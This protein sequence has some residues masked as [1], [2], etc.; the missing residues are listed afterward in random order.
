MAIGA[1][2]LSKQQQVKGTSAVTEGKIVSTYS[3]YEVSEVGLVFCV[4][5]SEVLKQV[6]CGEGRKSCCV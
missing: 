1:H 5:G 6:A 2:N 4:Y 3:L